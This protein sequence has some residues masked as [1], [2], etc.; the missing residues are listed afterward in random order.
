MARPI[1]LATAPDKQLVNLVMSSRLQLDEIPIKRREA[2]AQG[3]EEAKKAQREAAEKERTDFLLSGDATAIAQAV[4]DNKL[5]FD[6]V[7]E[8]RKEEVSKAGAILVE[9]LKEKENANG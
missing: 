8:E 2:I 9:Q 4:L 5:T 6:D 3:I 7:P 1:N